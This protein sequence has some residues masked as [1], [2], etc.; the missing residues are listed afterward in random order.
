MCCC[1]C[2]IVIVRPTPRDRV[3]QGGQASGGGGDA[4]RGPSGGGEQQKCLLRRPP[5]GPS[6]G[7]QRPARG[8]GELSYCSAV[9]GHAFLLRSLSACV[10]SVLVPFFLW[11]QYFAVK[12]ELPPSPHTPLFFE[13]SDAQESLSLVG[14]WLPLLFG[15]C[16]EV[17][18]IPLL[19][20]ARRFI[21]L[22]WEQSKRRPRRAYRR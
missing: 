10:V 14:T 7:G 21:L 1:C 16:I 8:G 12:Y 11:C 20:V 19:G 22:V 15:P 17:V 6:R 2:L 18:D 9:H 3:S 13:L 5:A 4:R